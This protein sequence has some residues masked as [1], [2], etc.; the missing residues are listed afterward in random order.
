MSIW[1][2][3]AAAACLAV[4]TVL[5]GCDALLNA[6]ATMSVAGGDV[7][8]AG[9]DGFCVDP[10]ASHDGV[11]GRG[12]FVLLGSCQSISGAGGAARPPIRAILTAAVSAG[13]AGATVSGNENHMIAFFR[14]DTGR[15]ALSRS[16]KAST[17][18]V[19]SIS[20]KG[21]VVFVHARDTSPFPGQAVSPDYWRAVF[22]LNG[23]IVTLSVIG[24]PQA[25][26]TDRTA[27]RTLAAFV[28]NVR[29]ESPSS[30]T[31][32]ATAS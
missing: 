14:S 10:V 23:R 6:P 22:D 29:A 16:G 11:P 9:P 13:R 17:V 7:V 2:S 18:R 15:R 1:T 4:V 21:G 3:K 32:P 28:A 24:V 27:L 25:P 19:L 8:V 20:A 31:A 12:A 30:G 5:T 26:F